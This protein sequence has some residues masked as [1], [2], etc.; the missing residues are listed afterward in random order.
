MRTIEF[1]HSV[2]V[3]LMEVIP[4]WEFSKVEKALEECLTGLSL[5]ASQNGIENVPS[6]SGP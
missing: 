4:A 1:I 5:S 6:C 3:S 2:K